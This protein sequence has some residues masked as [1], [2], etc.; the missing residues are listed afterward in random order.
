M[1]SVLHKGLEYKVDKLKYEK[2]GGHAAEDQKQ[3]W[4]FSWQINYPGSV[5]KV[6]Q[7]WLINTVYH[8]LVKNNIREGEGG[9]I[10]R[11]GGGLNFLPL[12]RGGLIRGKG[13]TWE[14]ALNR[15]FMVLKQR[16]S[17]NAHH[18]ELRRVFSLLTCLDGTK[19]LLPSVLL[20]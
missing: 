9:L 20:Y 7:S 4:P 19:F 8:L 18:P 12:R 1:V 17:S 11:W 2:V 13:L 14:G 5:H 16:V 10:E 15:G 3:I 6:K